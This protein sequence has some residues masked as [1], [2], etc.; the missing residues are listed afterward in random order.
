MGAIE[1]VEGH[2]GWFV[3]SHQG[4]LT[5]EA[6]LTRRSQNV[7]QAEAQFDAQGVEDGIFLPFK[8]DDVSWFFKQFFFD[9]LDLQM[10]FHLPDKFLF[11]VVQQLWHHLEEVQ[12]FTIDIR[13]CCIC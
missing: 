8:I 11:C 6:S 3:V 13:W 9:L 10:L 4:L 7:S 2:H 1:S 12:V 5:E